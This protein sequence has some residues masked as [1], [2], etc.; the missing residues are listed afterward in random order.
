MKTS[1]SITIALAIGAAAWYLFS[2]NSPGEFFFNAVVIAGC[3]AFLWHVR[4][5]PMP[6]GLIE[7][8]FG[9]ADPPADPK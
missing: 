5:L 1:G 7:Q 6:P 3:I 8:E 4:D 2:A 9:P